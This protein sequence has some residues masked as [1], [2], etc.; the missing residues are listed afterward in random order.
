MTNL[1][2]R[3]AAVALTITA[4]ACGGNPP[5]VPVLGGGADVSLLV[6]EWTG[7]YRSN[8]TGRSGSVYFRLEAGADTARGDVLMV[9]A[10]RSGHNHAEGDHPP[11]EYIDITFVGVRSGNVRGQLQRYVDPAC[12]CTAETTFEG[13]LAGD[14]I[15]GTYTTRHLESGRVQVG[16]WFANRSRSAPL[17]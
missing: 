7:E 6:G 11:S 15:S 3:L 2:P 5:P 14:R 12:R 1:A 4:A 9:A 17:L 10:D 16:T 13:T 8:E